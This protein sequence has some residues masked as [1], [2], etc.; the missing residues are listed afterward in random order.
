MDIVPSY[1]VYWEADTDCWAVVASLQA[2]DIPGETACEDVEV[3]TKIVHDN[4]QVD[5]Q[6]F[7]Q[8]HSPFHHPL[9]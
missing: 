1:W 2:L 9:G 4:L 7:H 3:D 6:L 8:L 5:P